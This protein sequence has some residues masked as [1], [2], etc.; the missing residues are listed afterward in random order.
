MPYHLTQVLSTLLGDHIALSKTRRET[1]SWLIMLVFRLG[2]TCLWR[3][4]AHVAH[5]AQTGSVHRRLER[6]FQ[7]VRLDE[8]AI[9][10]LLVHITRLDRYPWH[11]VLDRTNW[12]LG[13]CEIN[14]LMLGVVRD[15]VCIPL[16]WRVLGK[17]GNSGAGE[18]AELLE[19]L[20][21]AFPDQPIASLVG[22]RE[23]IGAD[24]MSWLQMRKIPFAL[25]LRA[26]MH[27]HNE[28][29]VPQRLSSKA[30]GLSKGETLRLPGTWH[31]GSQHA[32]PRV[33]IIIMRL[34]S[35]ELLILA[36]SGISAKKAL[37]RYRERWKIE[38]LFSCMK[39]RGLGLEDTHMINPGKLH[40]LIAV[41]AIAFV[42]TCKAGYWASRY[43]RPGHKAHGRPARSIF[44][45]GLDC[46]RKIV[47]IMNEQQIMR[48]FRKLFS[49]QLPRDALI[50]HAL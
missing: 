43:K 5:P 17:S 30:K 14:I 45:F 6:F 50:C 15:G 44:A 16:F 35:G 33:T 27:V 7:Y 41:L 11:L 26:N 10:H 23:F 12:K 38:T 8:T 25:R 1:L 4:A 36:A 42:M 29:Y 34:K 46:L 39:S 19:T 9:A 22:D 20:Q 37:A 32:A 2:T 3:M 28:H 40:T 13:R 21:T 48:C 47:T 24:W 31:L 49:P 18:R